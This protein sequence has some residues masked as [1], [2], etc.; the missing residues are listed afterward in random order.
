VAAALFGLGLLGV[1]I[2]RNMLIVL[3]SIELMLNSV[4]MTL[5]AFAR[6]RGDALGQGFA[7]LVI[8]LAAAAAAVGLAIV[9]AVFRSHRTVNVDNINLMKR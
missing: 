2:R 9:V 5:I 8:A 1:I 4:N 3:M 6:A 7:F